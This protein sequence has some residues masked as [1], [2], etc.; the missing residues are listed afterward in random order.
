M[1][2]IRQV[3][4]ALVS[5]LVI[6]GVSAAPAVA[7]TTGQPVLALLQGTNTLVRFTTAAP[8]TLDPPVIVTGL[9]SGDTLKAIDYRPANGLL[10][11]LA[12]DASNAVRLYTI[13][14]TTGVATGVG[15]TVTLATPGTFWDINFNPVVDRVRVVNDQDENAR[16]VPDTGA[17]AGD[18]T[19][20]SPPTV[21]VDA[22]AYTNPVAGATTT[23]LYALNQATNSL[24]IIGGL[25]G[26]PSPN[27]GVV[28]DIGPLGV[29]FA[30]SPTALDIATTNE[31]FAVLRPVSG[32][33]SL[34][35]INLTTGA[36]TLVGA[37][38]DGTL[39][40]DD[41]ALVDPG[42]TLS[43]PTGTYTNRQSFD[44]VL[45]ADTQGRAVTSGTAT[46]DGFDVTSFV[47][48]CIRPGTGAGGV[49]SFRCADI[50]GPVIG[51]GV[52]T[53]QVRLVM[54]DGSLVQRMVTWTVVPVSE[55]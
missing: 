22:V 33:T 42:L 26:N 38:G 18:D 21:S 6:L 49:L 35:S 2:M 11:A 55:P 34:Y 9:V 47:A 3:P 8:G 14:A 4:P 43:P 41:V 16:L 50:G 31:A 20:L 17:L 39:V 37:V 46:F 36:A 28:T 23:T 15:S 51:P 40:V 10:Y 7:Q 25:L 19:N 27:T 29:T 44:L 30:G 12:T 53:F 5:L 24:A 32:A 54:N 45:L 48:G 52:H 13:N 1:F